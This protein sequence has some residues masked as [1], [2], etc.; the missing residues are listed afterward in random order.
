[1]KFFAKGKHGRIYREGKFAIKQTLPRRVKNETYWIKKLNKYG[2][3][4]KLKEVKKDRFKY[5]FIEGPF[6]LEYLSKN[7]DWKIIENVLRQCRIMDRMKMNKLEM[8]NPHKHIIIN[9]NRKPVMIDFER[10]YS[11]DNPKNV[12]Q[13]CQYLISKNFTTTMNLKIDKKELIPIVK[14]YK[15]N[16]TGKNF[17]EIVKFFKNRIS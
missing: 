14:K 16:K 4:P 3:G 5:E 1:M 11:T 15:K 8:H 2:I 7:K 12:T 13:F 6:I 10:A 17:N 9:K